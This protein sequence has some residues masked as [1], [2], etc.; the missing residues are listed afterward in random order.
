MFSLIV[1]R[2]DI[3]DDDDDDDN[4]DYSHAGTQIKIARLNS[5]N[6]RRLASES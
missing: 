6:F 2:G 5:A 1:P 3:W 4:N